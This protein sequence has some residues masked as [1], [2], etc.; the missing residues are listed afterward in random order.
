MA[1]NSKTL[2][3]IVR[4]DYG[5]SHGWFVRVYRAGKCHSRLFSDGRHG[6]KRAALLQAQRFRDE[7][8]KSLPA[9]LTTRPRELSAGRVYRDVRSY[10]DSKGREQTYTVWAAWIRRMDGRA[11]PTSYSVKK[12]GERRAKQMAEAWLE[13]IAATDG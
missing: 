8:L 6:G 5:R 11:A 1:R 13:K 12:W 4:F 3:H 2:R 7:L 10:M 9:P